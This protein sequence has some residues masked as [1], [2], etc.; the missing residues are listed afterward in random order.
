MQLIHVVRQFHPAMRVLI[1]SCYYPPHI[2]DGSDISMRIFA[3]GFAAQG[4]AL[5]LSHAGKANAAS[6]STA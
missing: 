1:V 3:K 5:A 2:V 4:A 6:R